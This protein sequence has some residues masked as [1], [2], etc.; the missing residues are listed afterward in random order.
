MFYKTKFEQLLDSKVPSKGK[1]FPKIV[2]PRA[3]DK[4][5]IVGAGPAGLHMALSLKDKGYQKIKIFEK[6]DRH[7]GKSKDIIIDGIYRFLGSIFL[8]SD[9]ADTVFKLAKRYNAGDMKTIK[10]AGVCNLNVQIDFH[11]LIYL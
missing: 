4:V 8:T 10:Y 11:L 9:Y 7:G 1:E 2:G 5:C 6:T 3:N